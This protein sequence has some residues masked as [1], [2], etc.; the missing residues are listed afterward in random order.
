MLLGYRTLNRIFLYSLPH[1]YIP[2]LLMDVD[3]HILSRIFLYLF[4]RIRKPKFLLVELVVV[5]PVVL[6]V[7]IVV[8][9]PLVVDSF[10]VLV[11]HN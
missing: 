4:D 7:D 8:V 10:E 1:I 3:F 11:L 2:I 9:P 6:V 5:L